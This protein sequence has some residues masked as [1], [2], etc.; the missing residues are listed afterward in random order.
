MTSILA[1]LADIINDGLEDTFFDAVLTR[2]E[3][4]QSPAYDPADPPAPVQVP[5]PCKAIRDS[6]SAFD[7]T[8]SQITSADSKV[9][10]LAKSLSTTPKNG[11]IITIDDVLGGRF[12]AVNVGVDPATACWVI[13]GRA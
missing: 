1:E 8:N 6:Y 10:V 11:D 4:P 5:Y 13:Q 9:L 7:R 12:S 2:E 3:I